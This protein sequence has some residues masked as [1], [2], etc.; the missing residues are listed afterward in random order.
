MLG[1]VVRVLSHSEFEAEVEDVSVGDIVLCGD[2]LAIIA[3]IYQ[4]EPEY[5]KYLSELD[6]EEIKSFIPDVSE[7]KKIARCISLCKIN[8]EE[9]KTAPKVGEKL[10]AVDDEFLRNVHYANGEFRI[11]YLIPLM[12]KCKRDIGLVRS[13]LMRLMEIVPEERDLLE[14]ILAEIE[15]TRMKGVEL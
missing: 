15:Y 10:E 8:L 12:E 3:S 13:L 5:A 2:I 11:P 7:E 14:I 1:K 6:K 9:P 4:E